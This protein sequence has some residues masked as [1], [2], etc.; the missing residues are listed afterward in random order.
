M[1]HHNTLSEACRRGLRKC[2]TQVIFP[3]RLKCYPDPAM[4]NLIQE[5]FFGYFKYNY[6]LTQLME[7]LMVYA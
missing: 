1:D 2:F 6:R 5:N 3:H 4:V 7:D